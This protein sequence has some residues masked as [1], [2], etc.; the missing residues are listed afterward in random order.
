VLLC[1]AVH[2]AGRSV[3]LNP[4]YVEARGVLTAALLL[5]GDVDAAAQ[6]AQRTLALDANDLTTCRR[7]AVATL[8]RRFGGRNDRVDASTTVNNVTAE[9]S[10]SEAARRAVLVA[11]QCLQAATDLLVDTRARECALAAFEEMRRIA[12]LLEHATSLA[13]GA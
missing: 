6:E 9:I 12:A 10:A 11:T 13:D 1:E 8:H 2:R 4:D 3:S 5:L 7:L